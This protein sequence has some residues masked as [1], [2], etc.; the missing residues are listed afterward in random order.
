[1]TL[2][3]PVRVCGVQ[4]DPGLGQPEANAEQIRDRMSDAASAGARLVV[5]PEAALTGYVFDSRDQALDGAVEA[6][7]EAVRRV[8]DAC[9]ELG[10]WTVFGAIERTPVASSPDQHRLYNTAFLSSPSGELHRYRKVHTL[11]LGVDR[12]TTPGDEGFRVWE[13]PFGRVGLNICYDGSFP[14]SARA[15]KLLGAQL[16][17]LPTNWPELYLKTEQI[18]LR[19]LENHVNYIAVNRVGTERGVVFPGG[20]VAAG[21]RG[22]LLAE[23]GPDPLSFVVEMDLPAADANRVIQS[24]GKY[25]FD[26]VADRRPDAYSALRDL[27]PDGQPTGSRRAGE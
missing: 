26:Y 7:S 9:R 15:L 14:E 5:F 21:P 20:S 3:G 23:G 13:L 27:L 18:R 24:P 1:M 8:Q 17:V 25:E 12:F 19:A 6:D 16:I 11:C 4:T 22:E 10:V 2:P